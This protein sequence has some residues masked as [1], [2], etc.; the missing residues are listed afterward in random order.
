MLAC[1]KKTLL[2]S[3]ALLAL[4]TAS[5]GRL[6]AGPSFLEY[7]SENV[8]GTG[9]YP[10]DPKA[11]ATLVGLAP[12]TVTDATLFLAHGFPFSPGPGEFAGT[13]QI[14]V[15]SHQ[16][17]AHDGYSVSSQRINGPMVLTLDYSSLVPPGQT[18]KTLTLGLASDDFQFPDFGQPFTA[19]LNG[20]AAADL[21]TELNSLNESGPVVHFFTIGIDPSVLSASNI[22]TVSIDEGGDGGDGFAMDFAT[23]GVTTAVS[24]VPEPSALAFACV[25]VAAVAVRR[26][27]SRR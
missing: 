12:G 1:N 5:A 3:M 21:T 16:T 22:L 17:G 4:L 18:V 15:G 2:S 10:S 14:F 25:S 11:G 9:T 20:H 13:D 23:V 24:G 27:R 26:W 6:T 8:L 7:G 19:T